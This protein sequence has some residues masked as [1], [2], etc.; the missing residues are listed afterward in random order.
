MMVM[1]KK[2]IIIA[3][4]VISLVASNILCDTNQNDANIDPV[5]V[6]EYTAVLENSVDLDSIVGTYNG[7]LPPNVETTL[8]L[9]ADGTYLLKQNSPNE[10]DGCEV[11]NGV[12]KVFDESVLMLEHPASGDNIFYK[13]KNDS[14]IILKESFGNEPSAKNIKLY[15]LKK[16]V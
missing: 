6:E 7:V 11:L 5:K 8:T 13:A 14:S 15:V 10:T 3:V 16:K 1:K 2:L 9:N 12:F 4:F